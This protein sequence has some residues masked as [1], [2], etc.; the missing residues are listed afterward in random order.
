MS[1]SYL[2]LVLLLGAVA[3]ALFTG[4]EIPLLKKHQFRQYIR[5]EGPQSHLKKEGTPTMGGLAILLGLLL[6]VAVVGNFTLASVVMLV[7]TFLFALIGFLDDY[8]KVTAKHNLGLR[9]WQKLVLQ[10]V[11]AAGLALY[12]AY[13]SAQGT[14]VW[15]PFYGDYVEFGFFYVPFVAFVMVAMANAVNLTDGLD[16]LSSGV[17]AI[18]AIFFAIVGVELQTASP[19]VFAAALSGV[20][21]G[22]LVFNHHPAKL[23]MGDTGSMAL[24]G[25]LACAAVMMKMEFL[26]VIAG[27]IYVLEA[28]SVIIQVLYFKKTG[29][30]RFFRMAPL[31]HH[32]ELGGMSET[33]VVFLFWTISLVCCLLGYLVF[34]L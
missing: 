23:F 15:I 27:L 18:V 2:L 31:H 22:F 4:L 13:F 6:T 30:K 14:K 19:A 1:I 7:V 10:I 20:C 3:T 25:G 16:G 21:L 28:L 5:E 34:H 9:A 12:M 11:F 17:T 26:L 8:I 32:F 24:G 29:G 33:K